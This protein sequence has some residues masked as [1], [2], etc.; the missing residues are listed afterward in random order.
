MRYDSH[1]LCGT[2]MG[3][4]RAR[5][6]GTAI[7]LAAPAEVGLPTSLSISFSQWC[8]FQASKSSK[9][10]WLLLKSK[11]AV[12]VQVPDGRLRV[13]RPL[14]CNSRFEDESHTCWSPS[15]PSGANRDD[16]T[17][18]NPSCLPLTPAEGAQG[19]RA[20]SLGRDR[21]STLGFRYLLSS[22]SKNT[23]HRTLPSL[24]LIKLFQVRA[25]GGLSNRSYGSGCRRR[26]CPR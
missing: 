10:S 13:V 6:N 23:L 24:I 20:R 9:D 15:S 7:G 8:G 19:P 25:V 17:A 16:R 21:P 22:Y 2:C 5:N 11:S 1:L 18:C 3:C 12:T 26:L 14:S 4:A